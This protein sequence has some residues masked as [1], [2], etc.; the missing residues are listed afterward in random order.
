MATKYIGGRAVPI[1]DK[2]HNEAQLR[3]LFYELNVLLSKTPLALRA[4]QKAG[5]G[6]TEKVA[7]IDRLLLAVKQEVS[8]AM[9][10]NI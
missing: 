8:N 7:H 6:W 1:P 3:A 4:A 9:D 5:P 10:R 2:A